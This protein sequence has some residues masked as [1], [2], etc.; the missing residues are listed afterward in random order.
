MPAAQHPVFKQ[1]ADLSAPIWRY[2]DFTKFVSMLESNSL[3]FARADRLGDP[4]EGSSS[5]GNEQLRSTVY[6]DLP[7]HV[8]SEMRESRTKHYKWQRQWTFVNCWHMNV[9]ESAAMWKLYA[10]SNEAVAIKSSFG[11]LASELDD[12]TYVGIVTYIDFERDWPPRNNALHPYA[13]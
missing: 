4:F 3:F 11:Q 7:A 2:M 8:I 10:K 6:G 5:R 9:G 1:P 12:E 13:R